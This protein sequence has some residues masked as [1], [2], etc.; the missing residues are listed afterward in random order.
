MNLLK[1]HTCIFSLTLGTA[2]VQKNF[3]SR[4][5]QKG[6]FFTLFVS[7]KVQVLK[8]MSRKVQ[9]IKLMSR[10][11]Q[12]STG[13]INDFYVSTG[14]PWADEGRLSMPV[15]TYPLQFKCLV[16]GGID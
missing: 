10:Y 9:D 11:V 7:R 3:L 4:Y 14:R 5:V 1:H 12:E 16:I 8:I 13:S 15:Q 2:N 6:T